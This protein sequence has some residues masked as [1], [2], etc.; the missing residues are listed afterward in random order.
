MMDDEWKKLPRQS[1]RPNLD[2]WMDVKMN[3]KEIKA[4][5][6]EIESIEKELS[7]AHDARKEYKEKTELPVAP[8]ME[9]RKCPHCGAKPKNK[10]KTSKGY[11]TSPHS[12]RRKLFDQ[13]RQEWLA[14]R[15]R[16]KEGYNRLHAVTHK[17]EGELNGA[18]KKLKRQEEAFR[19]LSTV[20]RV[21]KSQAELINEIIEV[22]QMRSTM[23]KKLIRLYISALK[24]NSRLSNHPYPNM[25]R[26]YTRIQYDVYDSM[27]GPRSACVL[28]V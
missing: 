20:K 5:K 18:K 28:F 6:A 19:F 23:D 9:S 13:E 25:P 26:G 11:P 3:A 27:H 14:K 1:G 21:G 2:D 4:T 16:Y 15:W 24:K 22:W 12:A 17:L 7:K 8:D 10:C